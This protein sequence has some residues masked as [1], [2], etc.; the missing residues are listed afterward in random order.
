[1][2]VPQTPAAP[3]YCGHCGGDLQEEAYDGG[4]VPPSYAHQAAA[5][6]GCAHHLEMEPPRYCGECRRRLKVQVSPLGWRAECSRHG[7]ILS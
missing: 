1:M 3:R 7:M 4:A 5:H 2:T 6:Q